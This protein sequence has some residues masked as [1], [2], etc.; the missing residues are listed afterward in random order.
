MNIADKVIE[1]ITREQHLAPG[2]VKPDST[3]AEL[4][5]DSLDGVNILFALE[6]EFKIDI[7]DSV[8]QN[9]R[10][11]RQVA[12]ALTRVIEGKDISDLVA[13]AKGESPV[14]DS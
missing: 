14:P 8:A 9:M 7:P 10:S 1:I 2:V 13:M 11:V 4:G 5:I 3:F 12:D 6:Q